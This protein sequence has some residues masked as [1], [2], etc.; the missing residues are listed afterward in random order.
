MDPK[1]LEILVCPVCKGPLEHRRAAAELVCRPCRLAYAVKDGI[2]VM[3][4]DEARQL[5]AEE[6]GAA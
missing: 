1:L 5:S 4:A 6:A 3:L 2:P